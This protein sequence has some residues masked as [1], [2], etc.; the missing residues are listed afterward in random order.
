MGV[1]M[2]DPDRTYIDV[3]VQLG[4]DVT[5]FPGTMLQGSTT[6]GNGCELGPD[7]RLDRCRVGKSTRI[8]QATAHLATIGDDC[9]VG[10]FAVLQPGSDV[11]N[12]TVTGPF[13]AGGRAP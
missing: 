10:P 9:T 5:L 13:Y 4:T 8:E 11:P 2:V 1:T 3:T 12:G 6:I 7:V